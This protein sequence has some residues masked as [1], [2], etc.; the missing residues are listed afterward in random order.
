MR[1]LDFEQISPGQT[2]PPLTKHMT[3]EQIRQ[4]ADASG[5]RNPIHLDETFARTAGLPG[6]IA[7]GM[8]TMAFANQ[9]VTDWL[10]DR[11]LLK[12]LNG[13]F[14]GMVLPGDDVT[15]S[16]NVASKNDETRRLVINLVV[17]NQ[18][19]EKVFNKGVAEAEFPT[20]KE[21]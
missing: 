21:Q 13:R 12:S 14:A 9:M 11:S 15:C 6:V 4:Y 19:G 1:T 17:T 3:V 16:G 18:R 8:L 7:H 5:D 20:I 2:L 10:G